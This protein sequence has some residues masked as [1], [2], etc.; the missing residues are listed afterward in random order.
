MKV[1][2]L[3]IRTIARQTSHGHKFGVGV[4]QELNGI[5]I[6]KGDNYIKNYSLM[7]MYTAATVTVFFGYLCW[8]FKTLELLFV[9]HSG[10]IYRVV[11]MNVF[12]VA[13]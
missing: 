8:N 1:K 10:V 12:S 11:E 4:D 6:L 5:Q 13:A 3:V 7:Y 2:D 9:V